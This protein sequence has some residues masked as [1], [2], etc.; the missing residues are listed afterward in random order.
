M[1]KTKTSLLGQQLLSAVLFAAIVAMLGFVSIRFDKK[2]DW[3]ANH[4]NSLTDA[5]RK[6]L[7]SMKGPIKF[8]AFEGAGAE[9]RDS[10][11][12]AVER[13][14]RAK[15]DISLEF[16]DPTS[17]PKM[18]RDYNVRMSGE[19][20]IEYNGRRESL[21][22]FD[23]ASITNALQRLSYSSEKWVVFVEGHGERS[24][25]PSQADGSDYSQL[26]ETLKSKGLKVSSVN[27]V[28]TPHIPDN[29]AVLVIAS[30]KKDMLPGEIDIIDDYVAKGGNLLWMADPD[31]PAGL[32]KLATTL[33]IQW[34]NGYAIFP[35]Y[36]QIGLGSPA[37]YAALGYPKTPVTSNLDQITVFPLVRAISAKPPAPWK[38]MPFL[39]TNASSWLE[40]GP[41]DSGSV[42]L[43]DKDIRGPLDIGE[44]MARPVPA[45]ADDKDKSA[46]GAG[47]APAGEQRIALVGDADFLSDTYLN[48]LGNSA[49]G[50]NLFQWLASRDAQLDINIPPAPDTSLVM[51]S[52][53][54]A[55][56][57]LLFAIG[58]P[59]VLLAVGIGRWSMRRRR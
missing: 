16:V 41:I 10:V 43:D 14:E 30:P 34:L 29:T 12:F 50:V 4:V 1:S 47:A 18:V 33:G 59:I 31:Q 39:Q 23:E 5:S 55:V 49:L 48:Q 57:A 26:T 15:P 37:I 46:A 28:E 6:Q 35:D 7:E 21:D 45:S 40:T 51:G 38:A 11:K 42:T 9:N 8:L 17:H 52:V 2:L 24:I 13:Y 44:L 19:V 58:L 20:I 25:S 54:I 3:T 56:I 27:L 32:D 53:Q 36:Q 22:N